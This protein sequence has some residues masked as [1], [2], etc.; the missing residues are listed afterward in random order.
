M[1]IIIFLLLA[2]TVVQLL[3]CHFS[4][5]WFIALICR[6]L[7]CCRIIGAT[8]KVRKLIVGEGV[9]F[10]IMLVWSMLFNGGSF[11]IMRVLLFLLMSLISVCLML[12]DDLLYVYV[13]E[14]AD[15]YD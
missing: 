9:A 1:N 15:D 13:I 2:D 5:W 11:P 6:I 14:D 10:G 12:V 4:L 8:F 7:F 3:V